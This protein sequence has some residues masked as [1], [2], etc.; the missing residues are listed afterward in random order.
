VAQGAATTAQRTFYN[1]IDTVF[2]AFTSTTSRWQQGARGFWTR[3]FWPLSV[4]TVW[5]KPLHVG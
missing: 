1:V 3:G 2:L 5:E 4:R